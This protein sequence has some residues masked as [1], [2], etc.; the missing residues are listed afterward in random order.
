MILIDLIHF[1][2]LYD[3]FVVDIDYFYYISYYL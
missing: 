1:V 3:W 2:L